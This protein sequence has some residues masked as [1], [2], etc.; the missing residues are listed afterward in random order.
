M[1]IQF[2]KC[3]YKKC[4]FC[5]H[6]LC[7]RLSHSVLSHG[8]ITLLTINKLTVCVCLLFFACLF[9][10]SVFFAI[11]LSQL[12]HNVCYHILLTFVFF[13]FERSASCLEWPVQT[14]LKRTVIFSFSYFVFFTAKFLTM[15]RILILTMGITILLGKF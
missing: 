14:F 9:T 13:F 3:V 7:V 2:L 4:I 1:T 10:V 8:L 6:I 15:T 5:I 11:L 12:T